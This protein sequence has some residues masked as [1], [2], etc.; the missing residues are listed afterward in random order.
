MKYKREPTS[1]KFELSVTG[2]ETVISRG[3][4]RKK[5]FEPVASWYYL[6]LIGEIG[7]A[8]ALPIAGG[9]LMGVVMDRRWST[10]PKATLSLLFLGVIVSFFN[11]Y[12]TVKTIVKEK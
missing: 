2:E 1:E 7:F 8:I 5:R 11:L 9:T 6:G 4:V 12:R 3:K 10:T